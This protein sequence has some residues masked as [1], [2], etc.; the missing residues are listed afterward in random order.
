MGKAT[1]SAIRAVFRVYS[2]CERAVPVL[3]LIF[4]AST[5]ATP[6][7]DSRLLVHIDVE[8]TGLETGYHELI[9]VGVLSLIHI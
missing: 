7:Q 5:F 9:D 3:L 8:T 1:I 6:D 2:L 4:S